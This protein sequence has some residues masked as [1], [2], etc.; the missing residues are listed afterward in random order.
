MLVRVLSIVLVVRVVEQEVFFLGRDKVQVRVQGEVL[1]ET[2]RQG[3]V[4]GQERNRG[5]LLGLLDAVVHMLLDI[6]RGRDADV[7]Y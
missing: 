3:G 7:A 2:S 6:Q 4:G 5:G 1:R